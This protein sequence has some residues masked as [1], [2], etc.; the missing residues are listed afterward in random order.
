M[1]W[2]GDKNTGDPTGWGLGLSTFYAGSRVT[3]SRAYLASPPA[4]LTILTKNVVTKVLFDNS[5]KAIGVQTSSG[6]TYSASKE[7]ILSAGAIDSPRILL[8]SGVGPDAE[9]SKISIPVIHNLPGVGKNL[10]DH[11]I[12]T[13]TLLLKPRE[14]VG[15]QDLDRFDPLYN[16]GVQMPSAWLSPPAIH[17]SK[18]FQALDEETKGHLLKV[19]LIEFGTNNLSMTVRDLSEGAEVI[20]FFAGIMNSQSSGSVTLSSANPS[21]PLAIDLNFCSHPYD[22]RGSD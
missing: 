9:L 4:N 13:T 18:E 6:K 10:K 16:V 1:K 12:F 14:K 20:T 15:T 22:K 19:P 7:V 3:S 21:D 17:T 5:K 11:P 8:L 2:N